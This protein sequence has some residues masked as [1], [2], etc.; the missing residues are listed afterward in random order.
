MVF[1]LKS[2]TRRSEAMG[3]L[4]VTF[5]ITAAHHSDSAER[6]FRDAFDFETDVFCSYAFLRNLKTAELSRQSDHRFG[7]GF[8][9]GNLTD[10]IHCPI[11][12]SQICCD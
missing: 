2:S 5:S 11:Q 7:F 10:V 6:V 9:P 3:R 1:E 8:R 4:L 12:R